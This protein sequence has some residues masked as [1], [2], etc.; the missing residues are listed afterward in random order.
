MTDSCSSLDEDQRIYRFVSLYDAYS[1]LVD[2]SLRLSKLSTF[3][4]GNEG[5]GHILQMQD[6]AIFR[7]FYKDKEAIAEAYESVRSNNY[8]S[9]WSIESDMVAMWALYSPDCSSIRVS[10]TVGKLREV[11]KGVYDEYCW[12]KF[13]RAPERGQHVAWCHDLERVEY[14][15][16]H[17]LQRSVRDKYKSF[18]DRFIGVGE[19][20]EERFASEYK[21][22]RETPVVEGVDGVFLKDRSYSHESEVRGVLKCGVMKDP[23]DIEREKNK[24]MADVFEMASPNQLPDYVYAAVPDDFVDEICFDPRMPGYK[25]EILLK[26][27]GSDVPEVSVS[28]TF[29]RVLDQVDFSHGPDE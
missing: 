14:V 2:N 25:K 11:L 26:I 13:S 21:K 1:M 23:E 16:F 15:D 12:A 29:G 22:L 27:F 8:L 19:F 9:C 7:F 5:V 28:P 24:P 6:S 17:Q 18:Y 4:D 10:T 20:D 3:P